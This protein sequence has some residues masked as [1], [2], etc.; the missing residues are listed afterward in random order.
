MKKIFKL[1]K[2][3]LD[4]SE[5]HI[6]ADTIIIQAHGKFPKRVIYILQDGNIQEY[7][8]HKKI[9]GLQLTK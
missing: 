2:N 3:K 7:T 1:P 4:R 9:G 6:N 5:D 8:M